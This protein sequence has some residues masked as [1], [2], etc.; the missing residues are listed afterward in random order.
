[1]DNI[2]IEQEK[3]YPKMEVTGFHIRRAK[4]EEP[5]K[6]L[7]AWTQMLNQT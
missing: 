6:L 4:E 5:Q 7:D 1:L 3:Y 2:I